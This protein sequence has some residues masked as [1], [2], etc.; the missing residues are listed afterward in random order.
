MDSWRRRLRELRCRPR[1]LKGPCHP[2]SAGDSPSP[3]WFWKTDELVTVVGT[4]TLNYQG[5]AI[6]TVSAQKQVKVWVPYYSKYPKSIS[7]AHYGDDGGDE[8][9]D[10][11]MAESPD[12]LSG[13]GF[14]SGVGTPDLFVLPGDFRK[15]FHAQTGRLHRELSTGVINKV[16]S[17]GSAHWLDTPW[18]YDVPPEN[19]HDADSQATVRTR[20]VT[21]DSP[22]HG[23]LPGSQAFIADDDFRMWIMYRP[24]GNDWCWMPLHVCNWYWSASASRAIYNSWPSSQALPPSME[25]SLPQP[26]TLA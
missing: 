3:H 16:K 17:T 19:A 25:V 9:W 2:F 1:Q 26:R 24:P 18:G 22:Y 13:T 6:G 7:Q 5:Q 4:A 11:V 10:R 20:H 23:F 14:T 15:W 8:S 12:S 21:S